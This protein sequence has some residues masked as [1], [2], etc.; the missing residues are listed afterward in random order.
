MNTRAQRVY[1][2]FRCLEPGERRAVLK[3]IKADADF[4]RNLDLIAEAV[5]QHGVEAVECA[6]KGD[7]DGARA[8]SALKARDEK[9]NPNY[10]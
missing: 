10:P 9:P 7:V 8:A 6:L 5:K 4:S 1:D 2:A 3:Q